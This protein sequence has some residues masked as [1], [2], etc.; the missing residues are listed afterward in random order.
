MDQ[1]TR[2]DETGADGGPAAG[3]AGEQVDESWTEAELTELALSA[4]RD[5]PIDE[6]AVPMAVY[7]GQT[8][9]LLPE[10]YMPTPMLRRARSWRV[11]VVLAIVGAFVILEAVGL[12]S[13]FGPVVPG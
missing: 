7:L 9:G 1:R 11:P 13:T 2:S 3:S 4:D 12:C 10:W 5:A 6:D 8:A